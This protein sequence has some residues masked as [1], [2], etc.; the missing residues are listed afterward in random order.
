M[1]DDEKDDLSSEFEGDFGDDLP[2]TVDEAA[3]ERMRLVANVL[4]DMVRIPGTDIRVGADPL[5]GLLPVAGDVVSAGL[6]LYVVLESA[7]LGVSFPTLLRMLANVAL[8]VAGGS[9][10]YV[11]TVFDAA[12]KA[13]KRNIE[14]AIEDLTEGHDGR[15]DDEDDEAVIIEIT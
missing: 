5:L 3:V 4:D 11:G 9:V 7:R 10:P 2:E 8:D 14:L 13:N 1:I 15:H 12:W 6:S